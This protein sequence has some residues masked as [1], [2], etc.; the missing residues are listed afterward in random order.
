MSYNLKVEWD[1][2]QG[3]IV[4]VLKEDLYSLR[5]DFRRVVEEQRGY[6]WE[7]DWKADSRKILEHIAAYEKLIDYYGGKPL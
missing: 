6:V 7:T 4:A 3:L 2:I 1:T 5:N